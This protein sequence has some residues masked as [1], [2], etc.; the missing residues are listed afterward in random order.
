MPERRHVSLI[1][2]VMWLLAAG[3]QH[4]FA[5]PAAPA[6]AGREI[7][8]TTET[9]PDGAT[10]LN[11]VAKG[12]TLRK[13]FYP[14]HTELAIA[15]KGRELKVVVSATGIQAFA[16]SAQAFHARRGAPGSLD[17]MRAVL[18]GSPVVPIARALARAAAVGN[19]RVAETLRTTEALLGLLSGDPQALDSVVA[20]QNTP[21]LRRAQS[22]QECW[23]SYRRDATRAHAE[24]EFCVRSTR[25]YE[26][27]TRLGCGVEYV[28]RAEMAMSWLVACNGGFLGG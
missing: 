4:V 21:V 8:V 11:V 27:D 5:G 6:Q 28:L 18:G 7:Q 9:A 22:T 1:L 23:E 19:P 14:D 25:W 3:A 20:L 15:A 17:N 26:V 10:V 16:D 2:I 12:V 13:L 24:Y